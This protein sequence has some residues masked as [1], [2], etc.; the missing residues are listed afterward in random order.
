MKYDVNR[1]IKIMNDKSYKVD[2]RPHVMNIIGIRSKDP[3]V[4]VF[5]DTIVVFFYDENVKMQQYEFKATTEPGLHYLKNLINPKGCAILKPGQYPSYVIGLHQN[6]Y[7]ALVQRAAPVRVIRDYDKDGNYDYDSGKEEVGYFGINIHRASAF[8]VLASIDRYSA[9]CQVIQKP[10]DFA[11][12]MALMK[13][14]KTSK[15]FTYTLLKEI[16]L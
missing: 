12:F 14:Q 1:I 15:I 4:N 8:K 7:E 5:N 3:S 13:K 9:G 11:T 10:D 2:L 16:D 6:K